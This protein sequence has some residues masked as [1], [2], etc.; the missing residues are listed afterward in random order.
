MNVF[1]D[2]VESEQLVKSG[3]D[4]DDFNLAREF[5]LTFPEG[6]AVSFENQEELDRIIDLADEDNVWVG[7]VDNGGN[8]N[9]VT[10]R[11]SFTDGTDITFINTG[12]DSIP[13]WSVDQPNGENLGQNCV[14]L[15]EQFIADVDCVNNNVRREI[16]CKFFCTDQPTKSPTQNPT[17]SP[18]LN[19]SQN[20]TPFMEAD[21]NE[22]NIGI[23]AGPIGGVLVCCVLV[24]LVFFLMSRSRNQDNHSKVVE[25]HPEDKLVKVIENEQK[26][27]SIP[28]PPATQP[29]FQSQPQRQQATAVEVDN[30]LEMLD[31]LV[32]QGTPNT[33]GEGPDQAYLKREAVMSADRRSIFA[34]STPFI[35]RNLM[36]SKKFF[37][38]SKKKRKASQEE[39]NGDELDI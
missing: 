38:T 14:R 2:C 39:S 34:P 20:P 35:M 24:G 9:D 31:S 8:G 36:P 28:K 5:C 22:L 33:A 13:P 17:Q 3:A 30:D 6:D 37:R 11:F 4:F 16:V 7:L 12:A 1:D 25:L 15:S 26:F 21:E 29:S 23:I 18:T 27:K 32:A 19:P 10:G